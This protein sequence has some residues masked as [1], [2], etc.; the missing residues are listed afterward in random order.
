MAADDLARDID[1]ADIDPA[2]IDADGWRTLIDEG[3]AE[4]FELDDLTLIA[5]LTHP[6]RGTLVRRLKQPD[7]ELF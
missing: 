3:P 7:F 4:S 5:E 2:D 6:M 1:P